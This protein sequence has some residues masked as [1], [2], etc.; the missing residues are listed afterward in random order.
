MPHTSF[1][2]MFK[3]MKCS[4][5]IAGTHTWLLLAIFPWIPQ[6]I[7]FNK[8]GVENWKDIE[9]AYQRAGYKIICIG[10]DENTDMSE[11]SKEIEE[12]YDKLF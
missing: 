9:A 4:V 8:N 7:L 12:A 1:L 3:K 11:L 10:Y 6:I 2:N 5:G